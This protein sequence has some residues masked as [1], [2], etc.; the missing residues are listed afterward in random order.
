MVSRILLTLWNQLLIRLQLY[1][2]RLINGEKILS[3]LDVG[4]SAI[5]KPT[6]SI[7][8][9]SLNITGF[10]PDPRAES[11]FQNLD[12]NINFHPFGIAGADGP[13]KLYL[14]RKSHCSSLL[15]PL[16][17]EDQRYQ[18]E[19]QI[20][21]DCRTLDSFN[22]E[23]DIIKVDAQ[24]AELEILKEA[25]NTLS[26]AH[27]VELEVWFDQK[28]HDQARIDELQE[29]MKSQ[30]F[31]SA[32]FSA[33]YFDNGSSCSGISFGDMMFVRPG[34]CSHGYK[35]VLVALVTASLEWLLKHFVFSSTLK[36]K[37]RLLIRL[38]SLIA[39]FKNKGP[40]IY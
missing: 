29:F 15:M 25:R 17:T 26:K 30:G 3:Y 35:V 31:Q 40:I 19:R 14:T 33:I 34:E 27:V 24:G 39:F 1:V 10:D 20:E 9:S 28:Y 2:A 22:L 38:I 6:V 36:I 23:V 11:D 5:K 7:A 37:D 4:A 32:G 13:R 18:V 16:P 21:I 8:F 12:F